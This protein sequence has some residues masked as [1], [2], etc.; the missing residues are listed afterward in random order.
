MENVIITKKKNVK[1][2]ATDPLRD[3]KLSWKARG[4]LAYLLTLPDNWKGQ[5]YHLKEMSELDGETAI[6]SALKELVE[7]GYAKI[8]TK[9]KE[10][11][12][13]EGK[14]YEFFDE[15]QKIENTTSPL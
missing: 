11:G 10:N 1:A 2:I 15:K 8:R 9:V 12:R 7:N 5:I 4:I 13:F 3:T 14:Y 6:R